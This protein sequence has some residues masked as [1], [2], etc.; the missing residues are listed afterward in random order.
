[1]STNWNFVNCKEKPLLLF[2]CLDWGLGHTTRSVPLIKEFLILG[3]DLIVACNSSQKA[4]L[5]PEFPQVRFMELPGYGVTYG[6]NAWRTRFKILFQL[7]K[8]LTKIKRENRWLNEF[9]RENKIDG[10]ISDNRYGLYHP[11]IPSIFITHQLHINTGYGSLA[12]KI[13]Q[14]F[15]YTFINRFS[16]CWVPDFEKN[17]S[18][19]GILSHPRLFPRI[20]IRYIGPLSRFT[21][22]EHLVEKKFDLLIIISG[23]EPQRSVFEKLMLKQSAAMADKRI[24]LVRGLPAISHP[25]RSEG[26]ASEINHNYTAIFNHLDSVRLNKLV[27]ESEL[28][29]CRSGYT[30][31]MDMVK[32]KKK[33]I[34]IPTPGQPEQEYLAGYVLQNHLAL[35]FTQRE[36]DLEHALQEAAN[37][38]FNHIDTNMDE[39]KVTLKDFADKISSLSP[40]STY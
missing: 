11:S 37:F 24:A 14:K 2:S 9:T 13:S 31:I 6:K 15:L 4:I 25:E 36:F 28:I 21:S 5:E 3:C 32:L 18:L 27:C 38:T 39:Y 29:V 34:V 35:A 22:C 17:N 8:I 7:T 10:L 1:L 33:M 30:T 19:A 20:P 12:D 16:A 40:S 23:P 26:Y